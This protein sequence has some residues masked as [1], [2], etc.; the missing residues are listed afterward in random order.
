[1]EE[2]SLPLRHSPLSRF[3]QQYTVH[4]EEVQLKLREFGYTK[5]LFH[6]YYPQA[7]GQVEAVNKIIKHTL[8]R[9]LECAKGGWAE[10][11]SETLSS[12]RTTSR[13]ATGETPFTMAYGA[14]AMIPV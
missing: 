3:R 14:E 8:K 7:N 13:T 1:M 5:R 12:Y 10:E 4:R 2:H 9:K 11:L 6:P